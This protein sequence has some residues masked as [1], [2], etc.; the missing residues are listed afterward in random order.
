MHEGRIIHVEDGGA[1][2]VEQFGEK[3]RL[4]FPVCVEGLVVVQVFPGQIGIDTRGEPQTE[5]SLPG[6][7][8]GRNFHD[9]A[10]ATPVPDLPQG[11]VEFHRVGR[12]VTQLPVEHLA[13]VPAAQRAD[14]AH[15]PAALPEDGLDQQRHRRLA[16]GPRDADQAKVV[17]RPAVI[18]GR[19]QTVCPGGVRNDY[20]GRVIEAF[21][22]F[23]NHN[24]G[25]PRHRVADVPVAVAARRLA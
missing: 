21:V 8:V 13:Q 16:V 11:A 7:A 10:F 22:V 6:Q 17:R 4:G 15:R 12:G 20:R 9:D 5:Q 25:T 23:L 3:Q 14:S 2:L 24:G 18:R 1:L 19:H